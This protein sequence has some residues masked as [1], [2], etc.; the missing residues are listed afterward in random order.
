MSAVP[1]G[2]RIIYSTCLNV[3]DWGIYSTY[4]P[5]SGV[6]VSSSHAPL[7]PF[8]ASSCSEQYGTPGR[9]PR[10]RSLR[11]RVAHPRR[12][13]PASMS[14]RRR[15]SGSPRCPAPVALRAALEVFMVARRGVRWV[16]SWARVGVGGVQEGSEWHFFGPLVSWR[17]PWHLFGISRTFL[18]H[19]SGVMW[20]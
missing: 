12:L 15:A 18:V 16:F 2:R 10:I 7:L 4:L 1:E 20:V 3:G 17:F 11:T 19:W 13:P 9:T 6:I 14:C 5:P 8:V